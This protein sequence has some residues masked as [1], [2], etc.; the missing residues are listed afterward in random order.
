[1]LSF[2]LVGLNDEDLCNV[3][4]MRRLARWKSSVS[5]PEVFLDGFLRSVNGNRS[6]MVSPNG[7]WDSCG[8]TGVSS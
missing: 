8:P 1:M 5:Q 3:L 7:L 6:M 2:R 4:V